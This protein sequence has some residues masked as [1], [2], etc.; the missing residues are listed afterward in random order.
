MTPEPRNEPPAGG[1]EA[2]REARRAE[3]DDRRDEGGRTRDR[4]ER[5]GVM[6]PRRRKRLPLEAPLMRVVATAGIVAIAVV[7]A[8]IMSSQDSQGW[9]IGLVVSLVSLVLAALLWSS[10]R[11]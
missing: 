2:G 9:L 1:P 5:P 3:R 10:R 6:I 8:A 7:V 4:G 11:L